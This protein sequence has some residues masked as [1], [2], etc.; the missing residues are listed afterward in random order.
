MNLEVTNKNYCAIVVALSKFVDLA[1]CDNIKAALIFGNQVIVSKAAAEGDVGL[2]FPVE[3][4]LS[5]EFL[6]ANNLF[7]KPEWGN[8]DPEKKG[9]FEEHGRIKAVKFRGHKSE[10]FWIPLNSLIYLEVG[11][12]KASEL[13]V[14]QEFNTICGFEICRKYVPKRNHGSQRQLGPRKARKEDRIVD[15]QFRF[16]LDTENLRRNI[17]KIQPDSYIS[18]SD[19]WH[20]TSA[21]F[22]NVLVKRELKWYEKLLKRLGVQVLDTHYG[23][24]W[25]SRRVV[26]GVEEEIEGK[27]HFYDTDVWGVVAKEVGPLLPKGYTVYGEIVGFTPDGAPIQPGYHY[28]CTEKAHRFLVYRVTVTNPDGKVVELSWSQMKEFC[29]RSGLEM[30]KEIYFGLAFKNEGHSLEEWQEWLLRTLE[31]KFVYDQPCQHNNNEVP[32]E[33]IV[34]RIDRLDSCESYKLKNFAFLERETKLLDKGEV[35]TETAEAEAAN[36]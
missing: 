10:G 7:R 17:H 23:L 28:G 9:F 14:G 31:S 8:S 1:N 5:K 19:K 12:W 4:Q 18:I 2:F 3:T 30:V 35:D 15:G 22:A 32:A 11:S 29:E 20:G 25:S 27:Q 36:G 34:V 33:G 24:T 6:G 16:H 26:K 21:V 13:S